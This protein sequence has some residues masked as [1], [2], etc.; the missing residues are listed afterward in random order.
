MYTKGR[1]NLHEKGEDKEKQMRNAL[2]YKNFVFFSSS[3]F[4]F[5]LMMAFDEK[6]IPIAKH[7]SKRHVHE[8]IEV[9][10]EKNRA[11]HLC[12]IKKGLPTS[13]NMCVCD[14]I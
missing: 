7:T 8:K 6:S 2:Q 13:L 3:S 9:S 11:S 12:S 14:L 10:K 1:K 5:V 4:F